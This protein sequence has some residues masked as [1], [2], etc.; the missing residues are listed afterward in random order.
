MRRAALEL[1]REFA[2]GQPDQV[3]MFTPPAASF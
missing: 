3:A 1:D 2:R